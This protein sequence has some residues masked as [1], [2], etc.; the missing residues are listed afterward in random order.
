MDYL[1]DAAWWEEWKNFYNAAMGIKHVHCKCVV[2]EAV[3]PAHKDLLSVEAFALH[4]TEEGD[5][6]RLRVLARLMGYAPRGPYNAFPTVLHSEVIDFGVWPLYTEASAI[7][8]ARELAMET[9]K[10]NRFILDAL[11]KERLG[12]LNGL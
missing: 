3:R 7:S 1:S 11:V 6:Y 10:K 5:G 9:A 12:E 4:P 2:E 8:M